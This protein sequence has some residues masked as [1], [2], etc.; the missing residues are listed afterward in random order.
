MAKYK[1]I[2]AFSD[3]TDDSFVYHPGD[4]YPRDGVD[5]S[6]DRLTSLSSSSNR[7]GRPIIELIPEIEPE[8]AQEPAVAP[9]ATPVEEPKAK[10]KRTSSKRSKKS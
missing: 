9:D 5:V 10:P 6:V 8:V 4:P 1:V 3:L 7:L 2:V